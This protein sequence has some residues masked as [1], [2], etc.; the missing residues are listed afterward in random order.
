[1]NRWRWWLKIGVNETPQMA[2][3]R[4]WE[5]KTLVVKCKVAGQTVEIGHPHPLAVALLKHPS[6]THSVSDALNLPAFFTEDVLG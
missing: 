4:T 3:A 1:M 2:Y 6:F 5:W